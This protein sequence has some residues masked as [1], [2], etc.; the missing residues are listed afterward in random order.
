[1][2]LKAFAKTVHAGK[3]IGLTRGWFQIA[4]GL[5]RIIPNARLFP[6]HFPCIGT[7]YLD[8][9]ETMC[10]SMFL[11]EVPQPETAVFKRFIRPDDVVY[12]IGANFGWT[13]A[14]AAS[15]ASHVYAFEPTSTALRLLRAT[16]AGRP[17]VTVYPIA[18]G[19]SDDQIDC[20]VSSQGNMSTVGSP[21]QFAPTVRSVEKVA[22][23]KLDSLIQSDHLPLPDFLKCDVEGYELK[24]FTGARE[25]LRQASP[26]V[27]FEFGPGYGEVHGYKLS[28]L[29]NIIQSCLPAETK[30][31]RLRDNGELLDCLA[32]P[33]DASNNYLA[34]PPDRNI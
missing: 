24:V 25:T 19:D 22:I 16:A 32:E 1:M 13:T 30:F 14:L 10:F 5:R 26:I 33:A 7:V 23:R 15:L 31:Y 27:F 20:Y 11:D 8:L 4:Q 3:K 34:I 29:R 21:N 18:M 2:M 28:D 6:K 9:A 17:N 12:D